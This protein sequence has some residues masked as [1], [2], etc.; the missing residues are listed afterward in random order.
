MGHP[1]LAEAHS[2]VS[3]I[4]NRN[5]SIT[6]RYLATEC[7]KVMNWQQKAIIVQGCRGTP[8]GP[9]KHLGTLVCA[10]HIKHS[11]EVFGLDTYREVSA[12]AISGEGKPKLWGNPFWGS[13]IKEEEKLTS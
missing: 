2:Q 10:P 11:L 5:H 7:N 6:G 13:I 12:S 4:Y 8:N 1:K 9:K 3:T